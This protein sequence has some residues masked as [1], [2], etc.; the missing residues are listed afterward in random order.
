MPNNVGTPN[1]H[2][3]FADISE[4]KINSEQKVD[5]E[6]QKL[7]DTICNHPN[8]NENQKENF[9]EMF[10]R[11]RAVFS[12]EP[13]LYA[14][15]EYKIPVK[16]HDVYIKRSYPIPEAHL[17]AARAE[18]QRLLQLDIT[19]ESSS[20]YS[21][22]ILVV[23][24]KGGSIRLCMDCRF[25]NKIIVGDQESPPQV[26]TLLQKFHG[27][28][29]LSSIDL[30]NGYHQILIHPDPRDL[31]SF[32]FC[33]RNLRFKRLCFGLKSD[34][35]IFIKCINKV[36]Q[37]ASEYCILYVDDG[38]V[39]S[40]DYDEHCKHLDH[41]FQLLIKNNLTLKLSKCD[42]FKKSVQFLGHEIS[43]EGL[44][45]QDDKLEIIKLF[46]YPKSRKE[47]MSFIGFTQY[48]RKFNPLQSY[49]TSKFQH[50]LSTK[51]KWS[52][53]PEDSKNFDDFKEFF[54]KTV[55]Y[56]PDF[57]KDFFLYFH[58]C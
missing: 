3:T 29:V 41:I 38:I 12:D 35:Q 28:N 5:M 21:S 42:F 36:L 16:D 56:Y 53:T 20:E 30:T 2:T 32:L 14:N 47:L 33:G 1:T 46:P 25:L 11:N 44:K 45:P 6:F 7:L 10:R 50:L 37:D 24:K 17:P 27:R 26:D 55:L 57:S 13:G 54:I 40:K 52:W 19:E 4:N 58:R 18:I 49:Y 15:F 43:S 22:P 34:M 9:T 48:Y 39:F 31:L 51:K 23:P 8:L